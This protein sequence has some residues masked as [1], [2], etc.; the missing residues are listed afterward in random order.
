MVL[1]EERILVVTRPV[2]LIVNHLRA[3]SMLVF[4]MGSSSFLFSSLSIRTSTFLAS[5]AC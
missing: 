2:G 3:C 1:G 4:F 5:G